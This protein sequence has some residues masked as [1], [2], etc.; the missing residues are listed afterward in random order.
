MSE[1]FVVA[2]TEYGKVRGKKVVSEISIP[3]FQF[4]GI[5]YAEPPVNEKRFTVKNCRKTVMKIFE[6]RW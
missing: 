4:L 1:E 5:P 3:Y 6:I 2:N